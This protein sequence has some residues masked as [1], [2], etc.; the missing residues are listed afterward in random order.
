MYKNLFNSFRGEK[1]KK[2][3]EKKFYFEE[4]ENN[5]RITNFLTSK[6]EEVY[7]ISFNTFCNIY[8]KITTSNSLEKESRKDKVLLKNS[9]LNI[10]IYGCGVKLK[11][12][13]LFVEKNFIIVI[14][15]KILRQANHCNDIVTGLII[16]YSHYI[17]NYSINVWF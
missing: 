5:K 13:K 1:R 17:I 6:V 15:V 2:K 10:I 12:L 7:R 9:S 4:N 3:C 16:H 14:V 8:F 11:K